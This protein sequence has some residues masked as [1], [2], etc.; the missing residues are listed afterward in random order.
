MVEWF[1][2]KYRKHIQNAYDIY[3]DKDPAHYINT[4]KKL[5]ELNADTPTILAAFYH[6][7]K[8]YD[9]PEISDFKTNKEVSDLLHHLSYL[10]K[11]E[12]NGFQ[13]NIEEIMHDPRPFFIRLADM[14]E[15]LFSKKT[16]QSDKEKISKRVLDVYGPLAELGGLHE[17]S[18]DLKNKAF[19][20]LKPQEFKKITEY[21][22]NKDFDKQKVLLENKLNDMM[23]KQNVM[24]VVMSRIKTP[25]SIYNKNRTINDYIGLKVIVDKD[26]DIEKV[27]KIVQQM[28]DV[29]IRKDYIKQP[30]ENGYQSLHLIVE[31]SEA[32]GSVPFEVQIRTEAMHKNIE[33][34]EKIT[35]A[36]YKGKNIGK[37]VPIMGVFRKSI[38]LAEQGK[39]S[40]AKKLIQEAAA[41]DLI[42]VRVNVNNKTYDMQIPK[43]SILMDAAFRL[44]KKIEG[45]NLPNHIGHY[46]EGG[47]INKIYVGKKRILKNN[48]EITIKTSKKLQ[49]HSPDLIRMVRTHEGEKGLKQNPEIFKKGVTLLA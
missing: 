25:H 42:N 12:Q 5:F 20:T 7:I 47:W 6:G 46:V 17:V 23:L 35:H 29:K 45:L 14:Y 37:F 16:S 30:K 44:P 18:S 26:E 28:G 3:K 34:N 10:K 33:E 32:K 39:E 15:R 9:L 38:G 4:A 21:L 19:Q 13:S 2:E 41:Y 24:G 49:R 31:K 8:S 1:E 11:Q 48:D 27:E 43:N 40:E 36:V 22:K